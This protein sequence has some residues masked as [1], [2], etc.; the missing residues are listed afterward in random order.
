MCVYIYIYIYIY[1]HACHRRMVDHIANND[2][3]SNNN[4]NDNDN[5]TNNDNDNNNNDNNIYNG[6]HTEY[7]KNLLSKE[8][9]PANSAELAKLRD[10]LV[11]VFSMARMNTALSKALEEEGLLTVSCA[12][13]V[14]TGK[15]VDFCKDILGDEMVGIITCFTEVKSQGANIMADTWISDAS[16]LPSSAKLSGS[17]AAMFEIATILMTRSAEILEERQARYPESKEEALRLIKESEIADQLKF[18]DTLRV[19]GTSFVILLAA[20]IYVDAEYT[21]ASDQRRVAIV[22]TKGLEMCC[23][24]ASLLGAKMLH[25]SF[26]TRKNTAQKDGLS[27]FVKQLA[28]KDDEFGNFVNKMEFKP[29]DAMASKDV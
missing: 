24:F 26:A 15:L 28:D 4:N 22:H 3:N 20:A 16:M 27:F 6:D 9:Q 11:G 21:K 23:T 17:S 1:V 29:S 14:D 18:S 19:Y 7:L 2:N 25:A 13:K 12:T 10:K 5:N 8:E